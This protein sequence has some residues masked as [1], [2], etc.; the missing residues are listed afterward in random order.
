MKLLSVAWLCAAVVVLAA[1]DGSNGT[2]SV[3]SSTDATPGID[4]AGAPTPAAAARMFL[5]AAGAGDQ[6]AFKAM[7]C[8]DPPQHVQGYTAVPRS[9]DRVVAKVVD[10]RKDDWIVRAVIRPGNGSSVVTLKIVRQGKRFFVCGQV[11]TR[12]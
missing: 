7:L 9:G 6:T 3:A 12:S 5:R 4:P 1:C 11:P 10:R 8:G 2:P